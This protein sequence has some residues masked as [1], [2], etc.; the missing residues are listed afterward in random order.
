[1]SLWSSLCESC[2]WQRWAEER[3]LALLEE[4]GRVPW[5]PGAGAAGARGGWGAITGK[6]GKSRLRRDFLGGLGCQKGGAGGAGAGAGGRGGGG[7]R[8]AEE[9]EATCT[10][11]VFR[12]LLRDEVRW[13]F[14]CER[15]GQGVGVGGR[16]G[17]DGGEGAVVCRLTRVAAVTGLAATQVN[18]NVHV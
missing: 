4:R 8:R 16:G 9:E 1:V 18:N 17:G 2:G 5:D 7:E 10:K 11:E 15:R 14:S 6:D 3:G 12:R 13:Q